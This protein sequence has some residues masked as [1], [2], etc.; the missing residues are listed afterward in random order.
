MKKYIILAL[1][2]FTSSLFASEDGKK[3]TG[4]FK[5]AC[6]KCVYEQANVTSCKTWVKVGDKLMPLEGKGINAHESGLC[7]STGQAI[8]SG[9]LYKDKFVA[10]ASRLKKGHGHSH[11][12]GHGHSH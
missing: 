2:A 5:V 11:G 3:M 8:I 1:V 12:D 6:G 10:K 7:K 9:M 4:I